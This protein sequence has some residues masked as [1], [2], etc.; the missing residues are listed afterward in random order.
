MVEAGGAGNIVFKKSIRINSGKG[1][2]LTRY[3]GG[4]RV[5]ITDVITRGGG[6]GTSNYRGR[7]CAA[8]T[9]D[10][11]GNLDTPTSV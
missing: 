2:E 1:L 8:V 7:C 10:H 5:R 4:E 11:R 9:R 6:G 3:S